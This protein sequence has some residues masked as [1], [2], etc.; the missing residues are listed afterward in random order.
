VGFQS[1]HQMLAPQPCKVVFNVSI[2]K[3]M[4]KLKLSAPDASPSPTKA[5][6]KPPATINSGWI[7]P[8]L[9]RKPMLHHAVL[10]QRVKPGKGGAEPWLCGAALRRLFVAP[11]NRPRAWARLCP[12]TWLT[13]IASHCLWGR[14]LHLSQSL[15]G[16]PT[17]S[18]DTSR[19]KTTV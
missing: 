4:F 9:Q 19:A 5:Y 2:I 15:S 8:Y 7:R 11:D 17:D 12:A 10:S 16:E 3:F 18:P 1:Q 14:G 6:E 13:P